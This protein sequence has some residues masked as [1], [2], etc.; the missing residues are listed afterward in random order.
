MKFRNSLPLLLCSLYLSACSSLP[1]EIDG[2]SRQQQL[3]HYLAKQAYGDALNLIK[4]TPDSH[5]EYHTLKA[6]EKALHAKIGAFEQ[7]TITAALKQERRNNWGAAL[8]TYHEGLKKLPNSRALKKGLQETDERRNKRVASLEL[9]QLVTRAEWLQ[10]ELP[11]RQALARTSPGSL[12]AKWNLN[13]IESEAGTIASELRTAGLT[14]LEQGK[15]ATAQR[16]ISL[17]TQLDASPENIQAQQQLNKQLK[18]RKRRIQQRQQ[19]QVK[20]K[21]KSQVD[22]FNSAMAQGE[23]LKARHIYDLLSKAK[24]QPQGLELMGEQLH[25]AIDVHV[26]E[27]LRIGDTF[28]RSG[29][30]EQALETWRGVIALIPDHEEALNKIERA[31]RVMKNLEQIQQ[32]QTV[33]E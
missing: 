24:T 19:Q 33:S 25:Q 10:K 12:M 14:A 18:S 21:Q 5:P 15:L 32:R 22:A 28:Y 30:F 3:E 8:D 6:R 23:L 20:Q 16:T 29:E 27:E 26:A 11:L 9:E 31:N 4:T 2:E 13:S 17:A 1:F 7:R